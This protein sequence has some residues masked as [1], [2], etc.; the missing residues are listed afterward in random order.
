MSATY[1]C[2]LEEFHMDAGRHGVIVERPTV[3][4]GEWQ[5]GGGGKPFQ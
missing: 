1:W 2:S 4:Q 5:T 3:P